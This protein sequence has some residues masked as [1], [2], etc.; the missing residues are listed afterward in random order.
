MICIPNFMKTGAGV[1]A[2]LRF[3]FRNLRGRNVDITEGR[4][5]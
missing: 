3:C 2:I 4:D 1:Q 5:L